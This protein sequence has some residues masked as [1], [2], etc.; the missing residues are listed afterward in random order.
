MSKRVILHIDMN[1]YFASVAM[2]NDPRL[3]G[4]PVAVGGLTSRSIITTAS[5]EA[6]KYGVKSAMPVF[7]AKRLCK[8][9][10]MVPVDFDL[11]EK[12]TNAFV[13]VIKKYATKIE[14][15]SIDEC[16]VDVSDEIKNHKPLLWVKSIQDDILKT[17]GLSCS[18][19]VAPNKFLAKMA[20]DYKK[21]MGITVFG[22]FNV[23]SVLWKLSINEMYGIGKK[24]ALYLKE[25]GINT[26][27]DFANFKN[28]ELLKRKFG[29]SY[30]TL[31]KWANGEDDSEVNTIESNLKSVG[32]SN[33]LSHATSDYETLKN[34][35]SS[36]AKEVSS[37]AK[38]D[39]L[40]GKT[41]S[42]MIKYS[43]FKVIS[44]SKK[45]KDISNDYEDIF[46]A[47][48]ELLD[49]HYMFDKEIRLLGVTLQNVHHLEHF[50]KQLSLFENDFSSFKKENS[51]QAKI[52][53]DINKK[54][55]KNKVMFLSDIKK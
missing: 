36:L 7:M 52:I 22:P 13:N 21:P 53:E 44:R 25:I 39:N 19:G 47:A 38:N 12:Y 5:Y 49:K 4:K 9:L 30:Y 40:Y 41:V 14:M 6:R 50:V 2:V 18:I 35:I 24:S 31:I 17:T 45:L 15:A 29:K 43:D 23:K 51:K 20:S 3:K 32:N 11:Y 8:D 46:I 48:M 28:Q 55:G 34:E 1:A 16:Y 37:R 42:L 33:T 27:G 10:I 54:L 26:I